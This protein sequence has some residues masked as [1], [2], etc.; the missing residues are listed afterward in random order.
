[1]RIKV[2]LCLH[3]LYRM[4][5]RLLLF[6]VLCLACVSLHASSPKY[7]MRAVWLTTNWGLDWPSRP[8]R[9]PADVA[10][11]QRE[12]VDILDRLQAMGIN[13]VFFQARIRGEVFYASQYE[14][15]AGVLSGGRNP[16]YDPLAFVVD[17]CH[18]RAMECHAW[19]V[20]FPIGSN[21]QVKKQGRTS[22]VAR[23][24]SWCKQSAGEWFLDPGN[25]EVRSYLTG[26]V[27]E[28][29]SKYDVDGIHLDYVRYPDDARRFPDA[30]SFRKWGKG[31]TSRTRWREQN[32]TATVTAIYDEVKRLKPWVKVSSSPL[33]RY[34]SL[35][36]FPASWSCMEAVHQNPKYW[37]QAG[38]H[39]FI[40]PMM[41][42]KEENYYPFLYDWAEAC[43]AGSV[44]SGIGVYR[45]DRANGNWSLDEI[46]RQI[47]TT[48]QV[49]VGQAYFR[50]ENLYRHTALSQ[51]LTAWFYRY[52]ALTP[53]CV[54]APVRKVE[55][56][57]ALQVEPL[58]GK[59]L[60]SWQPVDEAF[61]YII[62]ATDDSLQ[63]DAGEQIAAV[64][65]RTDREWI[66]PATYRHYAVVARDR[67]GN[68]S[69]PAVW[70]APEIEIGKYEIKLYK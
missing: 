26:L 43:P 14:P 22:M 4:K 39:D 48:R 20:T 65:P 25:P 18:K 56:P 45:L 46:R 53:R 15:W 55:A 31:A 10:R 6:I 13:T 40:A 62:Y 59:S 61:T 35:P 36:G 21:R 28:V 23:H 38:K 32:I 50:Y 29:V 66:L 2:Y 57:G 33:G 19:L 47:E 34:A 3:K 30:D 11:Q 41:Y 16:G 42:F 12:L 24:R 8:I 69:R 5:K 67:Y 7:E 27:S 54:G 60:L 70:S 51:W 49:G 63:V 64:V 17:E 44:A 1:M 68:E 58:A 37:L 52:L 9:R